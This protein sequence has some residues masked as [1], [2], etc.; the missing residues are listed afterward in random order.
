MVKANIWEETEKLIEGGEKVLN[1]AFQ[2]P[3]IAEAIA[4]KWLQDEGL[5]LK[6]EKQIERLIISYFSMED[7]ARQILDIQPVYYDSARIW[8][9]WDE[10]KYY[11]KIIDETD[12]LIFV[13]KIST[14]NTVKAKERGEILEAIKQESR[15]RKP[16]DV[17]KNWIQFKEVF[18]DIK[19][20][21]KHAVGPEYFAVNPIQTHLHPEN[22]EQTPN[23]DR[24]FTEWVGEKYMRTLYEIIAYCMLPDYPIHRMFCLLGGGMNGKTCFLK[25]IENLIGSENICTTELDTLMSSRFEVTKLYK[26]LVCIMGETNFNELK[27][28]SR[29]KKLTGQ[30]A[31]GFEYKNKTPFDGKNYAKILLAT[32]NLPETTDKTIGFYRR[33][34][35][36]DFPNKFS[37]DKDILDDIPYEEMQSLA[38]KCANMLYDLLKERKF[39]NEG[40]LEE[41]EQRYEEKSNPLRKFVNENCE[42]EDPNSYILKWEFEKRYNDWAIEHK[43]R[44]LSSE[45]IGKGI[46]Q[47]GCH[48]DRVFTQWWDGGFETKK[49]IRAWLGIKWKSSL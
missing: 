44:K 32:N 38:L 16:N 4:K 40:G 1:P 3:E 42:L 27:Q 45:S 14:A 15:I 8:W 49:Q 41:R 26:K 12:I 23:I 24:I 31:I 19:N 13:K 37:E 39:T 6:S 47:L 33:W 17:P 30:D 29:I 9:M 2:K 36:I 7:L 20:G 22:Y 11:W 43:F 28:T 5:K 48:G 21:D 34:C 25:L 10:D 46:K 35:I 18:F